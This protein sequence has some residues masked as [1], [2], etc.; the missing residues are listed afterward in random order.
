[1]SAMTLSLAS[2][3]GEADVVMIKEQ[4]DKLRQDYEGKLANLECYF[5]RV[6]GYCPID[7]RVYCPTNHIVLT[8]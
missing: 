8:T 4:Q 7:L 2:G 1:M 5:N 6:S 3:G